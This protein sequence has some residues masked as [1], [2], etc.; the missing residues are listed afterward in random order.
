MIVQNTTNSSF[1]VSLPCIHSG[2]LTNT[3]QYSKLR[4][5]YE[6]NVHFSNP[7]TG[8]THN[9]WAAEIKMRCKVRKSPP[10]FWGAKVGI[11]RKDQELILY[12]FL[13]LLWH[14]TR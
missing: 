14:N 9:R 12:Q 2:Y 3:R 4:Y 6:T 5:F 13:V 8:Q 7:Q 1:L 10:F 11:K